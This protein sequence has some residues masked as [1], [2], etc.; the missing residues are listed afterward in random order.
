MDQKK[1]I[2]P[3]K[4]SVVIPCYNEEFTLKRC[5]EN[6]LKIADSSLSLEL[7]IVDDC[8]ED[9]S[10][11]IALGLENKYSEI[12]VLRH[13]QNQGKGAALRTG[14][15]KATGDFIAVQDADLEYDPSDLK[16]LMKP[17]I[18]EDADVVLGSR[19]LSAGFH[20]VL[21]FWHFMGNRFLTFI[22]NML[23]DLNLTDMETCYK[24]FRKD[25]IKKISI[26]ENRFGFEPEIVAKIAHMRLRIFEV[27]IS[28]RGRTYEE[29]KKIRAKDGFR[30]LYCIFKYNAHR[31]PVPI[32]LLIYLLIGG[33]AA[34]LNL[35]TFLS[36]FH[37]GIAIIIA[38]P[39][40]FL[41][42]AGVNYLLCIT[43]LFKHKAK[44]NSFTE[45]LVYL[46]VISAVGLLDLWITKGLLSVKFSAPISKITATG[47]TFI[48]NFLGRRKMV[49]PEKSLGPWSPQIK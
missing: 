31:A 3:S 22:S 6:V 24:V 43:I 32:Q 36:L 42:S 47:I 10:Y 39:T 30:A 46:I 1:L 19:F 23:T 49:F 35:I 15:M 16:R 11:S 14:F 44:W 17:L 48:L 20:R 33:T 27:G 8:S 34:I 41:L 13:L 18:N 9:K 26:E 2:K 29:G 4:L 45:I 37:L 7:I 5:I 38:A 40:A 25:I 12:I 21:Y 28:Y